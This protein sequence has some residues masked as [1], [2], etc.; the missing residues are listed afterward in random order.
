MKKVVSVLIAIIV[1][2]CNFAVLAYAEDLSDGLYE[3]PVTLVHKSEEKESFGNKYIANV[4]LVKVEN[5]SKTITVLLTTN[6]KGIEFSYF[7]NGS[8]DG[9]VE[10]GV[11]VS[12]VTV[13]GKTYSQGFEIPVMADGE[14]GLKF[15]VPVMPMSPSA[16]LRINYDEAVKVVEETTV[17]ETTTQPTTVKE[18]TTKA[19]TTLIETTAQQT[20][21]PETYLTTEEY[22]EISETNL[23]V[24]VM[25]SVTENIELPSKHTPYLLYGIIAV[26]L[27]AVIVIIFIFVR[28]NKVK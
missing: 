26:V 21:V 3:V 6:M 1:F 18:T 2:L 11:P 10:K 27:I 22:T 17:Y 24:G 25:E 20:T 8:L 4:A 14:I 7:T 15:S 5:G 12:N 16:R 9:N 23:S 19:T 28:R 13:S